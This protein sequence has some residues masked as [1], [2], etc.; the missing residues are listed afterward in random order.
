MNAYARTQIAMP[1]YA[2]QRKHI[3]NFI[4]KFLMRLILCSKD[5]FSTCTV[6]LSAP[7]STLQFFIIN[8]LMNIS[9]HH[10]QEKQQKKFRMTVVMKSLLQ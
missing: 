10:A 8:F 7:A 5:L 6:L 2:A 1:V 3:I 4:Y 9:Y